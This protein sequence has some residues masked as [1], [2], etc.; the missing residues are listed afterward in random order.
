M[1]GNDMKLRFLFF[2]LAGIIL[3]STGLNTEVEATAPHFHAQEDTKY[4]QALSH[5][6]SVEDINDWIKANFAYSM[7]KALN[8]ADPA[9]EKT[10]RSRILTPVEM[11]DRKEGICVDLSRFGYESLRR[12]SPELDPKYLMIE[13]EP[14]KRGQSVL[15]LHWMV[16]YKKADGYY[17]FADSNRPGIIAGP[18]ANA[19]SF[20]KE[21]ETFRGRKVVNHKILD[22][23]QKPTKKRKMKQPR[24]KQDR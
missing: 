23:Y 7:D 10:R 2:L 4:E 3:I 12:V 17:T 8:V 1:A 22:S 21:Y 16:I 19:S 24:S 20:L 18:Y 14:I 6:N 13:F 9:N 11:F 15:R 5:W